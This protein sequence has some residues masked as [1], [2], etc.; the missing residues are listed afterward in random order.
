VEQF[1]KVLMSMQTRNLRPE[2]K[3]DNK[4]STGPS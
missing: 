2:Q 3:D 1:H 4:A